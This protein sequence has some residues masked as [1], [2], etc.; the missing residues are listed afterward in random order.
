[1]R[2]EY[3]KTPARRHKKGDSVRKDN[4]QDPATVSSRKVETAESLRRH[5][6][7]GRPVSDEDRPKN[8]FSE[9]KNYENNKK[10]TA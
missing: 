8:N 3:H 5:T 9:V 7:N 10:I 2:K 4:R 1:M 6:G